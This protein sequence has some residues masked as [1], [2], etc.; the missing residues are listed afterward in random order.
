MQ[1]RGPARQSLGQSPF[2][3]ESLEGVAGATP[4]SRTGGRLTKISGGAGGGG[5]RA[6]L[7]PPTRPAAPTEAPSPDENVTVQ[8][9]E[10][11]A[12]VGGVPAGREEAE[13]PFDGPPPEE[14][15]EEPPAEP[16]D[17]PGAAGTAEE[18][19]RNTG[20]AVVRLVPS[21]TSFAVGET[22]VVQVVIDNATN[23]GS[24]PFHLRYNSQVLRFLAPATEGPFLR[25]DGTNTVFLATDPGGGGEVVVGLS[26]MGVG[27]GANGSGTLAVFQFQAIA[28]GD[29]GFMFTGASVKDPQAR[30]LPAAFNT[31]VVRVQ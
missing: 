5:G 2:A 28:P 1:L 29:C 22:V 14:E 9:P 27:T 17:E 19:E 23:I 3:S 31:A 15:A 30:N 4:A 16:E 10:T 6:T 21:K 18:P 20:P 11:G 7:P 26:R 13:T 12:V 8:P 24:T 25:S